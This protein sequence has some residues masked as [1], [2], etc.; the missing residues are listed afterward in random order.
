[1][2]VVSRIDNFRITI[3]GEPHSGWLPP[4]AAVPLPTPK[5]D[6]VLSFVIE[7]DGSGYLLIVESTDG[8]VRGDTWHESVADAKVQAESWYGVSPSAWS[9]GQPADR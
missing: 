2:S 3:G 1:M 5:R 9:S 4:G 6:V 8:S 7:F